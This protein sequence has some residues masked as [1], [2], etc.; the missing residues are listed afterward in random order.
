MPQGTVVAGARQLPFGVEEVARAI[1]I[2]T[3]RVVW[4]D[5]PTIGNALVVHAPW[6]RVV[7]AR[8]HRQVQR[9]LQ[10]YSSNRGVGRALWD[11]LVGQYPRISVNWTDVRGL[12]ETPLPDLELRR[13]IQWALRSSET[14]AWP[15]CPE[16]HVLGAWATWPDAILLARKSGSGLEYQLRLPVWKDY[17]TGD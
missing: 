4:E 11:A 6:A 8:T 17:P 3:N 13:F 1:Q 5:V 9:F 7:I 15:V 16:I 2:P 14:I 10:N 12:G